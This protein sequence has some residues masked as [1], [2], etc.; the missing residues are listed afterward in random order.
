MGSIGGRWDRFPPTVE[1][2]CDFHFWI[3]VDMHE[4]HTQTHTHTHVYW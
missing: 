1:S 2:K 4:Y 3:D